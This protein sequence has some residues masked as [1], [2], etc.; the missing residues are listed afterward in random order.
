MKKKLHRR[1]PIG[2]DIRKRGRI[3]YSLGN[4]DRGGAK[5]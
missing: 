3:V 5:L 2:N 1:L 4:Y